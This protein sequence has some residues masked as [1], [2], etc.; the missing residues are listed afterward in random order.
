[1]NLIIALVLTLILPLS[2]ISGSRF[3]P[4]IKQKIQ[5]SSL[6]G[7]FR[8]GHF[9][10]GID[11]RTGGGT[12]WRLYAADDGYI[13]RVTTSFNGYGR[14]LYLK[15]DSGHYVVYGHLA[16]F[17]PALARRIYDYQVQN[18]NYG[19]NLFFE[20]NDFP[21]KKG[22]FIG[23]SGQSGGGGPHL[24]YEIRSPD[25]RPTNPLAHDI[26]FDDHLRPVFTSIVAVQFGDDLH[27]GQ[28]VSSREFYCR[29]SKKPGAYIIPE[30]TEVSG[31]FG[32]EIGG[33]DRVDNYYGRM[34]FYQINF[35][36]DSKLIFMY[37]A[38]TLDFESFT[39][40]DYVRDYS[41]WYRKITAHKDPKKV[42]KD[43]YTCYRLFRIPGDVQ[44]TVKVCSGN[45]FF[46]SDSFDTLVVNKVTPGIHHAAIIAFDYFGNKAEL[47]FTVCVDSL[48][49]AASVS[50][51]NG[52]GELIPLKP[53]GS[54]LQFLNGT[55]RAEITPD[56]LYYPEEFYAEYQP[57]PVQNTDYKILYEFEIF[58][59]FTFFKKAVDLFITLDDSAAD[60]HQ[61]CIGWMDIDGQY[62]FA[63]NSNSGE[64]SGMHRQNTVSCKIGATGKF[65]LIIDDTPP[66][67][68]LISPPNG[69]RMK[70]SRDFAVR[71]RLT[72]NFS[73]IGDETDL[74]L[75][76]DG[77]WVPAA[78][79]MDRDL[80]EFI[81]P[82][83]LSRGRHTLSLEVTDR[84][85]NISNLESYFIVL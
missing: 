21:V 61:H 60:S 38:D 19:V 78:Y 17:F 9:H 72:D 70:Y 57:E 31:R 3:S 79:D 32:F 20:P 76:L 55:V 2:A 52:A 44:P 37:R 71:Y 49:T 56:I 15:C 36:L 12:G 40:S 64:G 83:R 35:Y 34:S 10:A 11:V 75:L 6:F 30:K 69:A 66:E 22:Q 33:Y 13:W 50:S 68:T 74:R 73:G 1:M 25:N 65:A 5:V 24:H 62:V 63:G 14:A 23:Y 43:L 48:I 53:A 46:S 67:L 85:G 45:G 39:Q 8:P 59:R 16:G 29:K 26:K 4:P 51:E 7:D 28:I 47:G 42:D 77:S 81:P 80:V 58:P 27:P 18:E 84:C 41:I 82:F 54:G